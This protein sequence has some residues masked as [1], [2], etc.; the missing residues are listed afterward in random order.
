MGRPPKEPP[1][2]SPLVPAIL[3]HLRA[4][5]ADPQL[6]AERLGL[7]ADAET[8]DEA[9]ITADGLEELFDSAARLLGEPA[10]GLTL[11]SQIQYRRYTLP[12]LA[13]RASATV[14]DAMKR[15]ER[16]ASLFQ[17]QLE[18][19]LEESDGEARWRTRLRGRPRGV[20]RHT[21][22]YLLAIALTHVR[23]EARRPVAAK[24]VWFVHPRPR[25][26]APIERFFGTHQL[27]FGCLDNG[28]A[29]PLE[30]LDS[31]VAGADARMLAT[32][33][34]IADAA[35]AAQPAVDDFTAQVA[36]RLRTLLP[37]GAS[38]DAVASAMHMSPRT[39]Q[40]RLEQEGTRFTD[41]LDDVR[42]DLAKQWL[43][44]RAIALQ[45]VSWRLGFADLATF[46]R[47][48]KRWTG[49]PP[50]TWR[51]A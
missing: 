39:L 28:F 2:P 30:V 18:L 44:D 42:E 6:V 3:R 48:F 35:L 46:S 23:R 51:R 43:G 5:G 4:R 21:H 15:I 45:E 17:P 38:M 12:E 37:D 36:A 11:P 16:Y 10:L 25:D 8:R 7:P 24:R 33:E 1:T 13:A 49:K 14:R 31:P 19:T 47:A 20:G 26:I 32:V 27:D 40:R 9:P 34:P 29:L 41:V 22:E 50:G